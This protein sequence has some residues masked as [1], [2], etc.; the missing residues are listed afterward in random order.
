ME[1][2]DGNTNISD[3]K[4][5]AADL[6]RIVQARLNFSS[7]IM[8]VKGFGSMTPDGNWNGMVGVLAR[9]V[10]YMV[11]SYILLYYLYCCFNVVSTLPR[12]P[13]TV[14]KSGRESKSEP[15]RVVS[16]TQRIQYER[17]WRDGEGCGGEKLPV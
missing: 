10:S 15:P 14:I 1:Y 13:L 8:N 4:G 17:D 12:S 2:G 16:S 3:A 7:T 9:Q 6:M 11:A 5:Y